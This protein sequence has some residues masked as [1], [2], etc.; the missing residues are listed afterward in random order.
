[1]SKPLLLVVDDIF[2]NRI[3]LAEIIS[4]INCEC[5]L[6]S[7]GK[8]AIEKLRTQKF[9]MVLMDIEMPVM[10]GLE[11]TKYIRTEMEESIANT[12]IVALTAHNP[13]DFFDEFNA[14]G[15]DELVTKP[16][17]INKIKDIVERFVVKKSRI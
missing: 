14:A 6:A 1:M 5:K 17:L 8:E 13:D 10:N 9:D 15:F 16:Y 11:T 3:L 12:P 2:V 7:N 4:E